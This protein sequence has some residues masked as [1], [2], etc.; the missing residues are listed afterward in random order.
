MKDSLNVNEWVRFAQM[1]F[2]A[3]KNMSV[4]HKPKPLEIICYHCQQSAEKILKAYAIAQGEPLIKTHDINLILKQCVKYD[5]Q[6][7]DYAKTCIKLTDYAVAARYPAGEDSVTED[8]MN[9]ALKDAT[10]ILEFTKSRIAE[11]EYEPKSE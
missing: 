9:A 8:D 4:L 5:Q 10:E 1:D 2:D 11:L 7:D 3:A 6:F